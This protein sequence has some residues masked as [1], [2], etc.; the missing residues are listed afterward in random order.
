MEFTEKELGYKQYCDKEECG[1]IDKFFKDSWK[2]TSQGLDEETD[3]K[4]EE[5]KFMC[6][7]TNCNSRLSRLDALQKHSKTVHNLHPGDE[8]F[9]T[10]KTYFKIIKNLRVECVVEISEVEDPQELCDHLPAPRVLPVAGPVPPPVAAGRGLASS[11]QDHRLA[12]ASP[13]PAGRQGLVLLPCPGA[14]A[15]GHGCGAGGKGP[16]GHSWAGAPSPHT[17]DQQLQGAGDLPPSAGSPTGWCSLGAGK[18]PPLG[19]GGQQLPASPVAGGGLLPAGS[20]GGAAWR[21]Q[22]AGG[23]GQ[24]VEPLPGAAL[25]QHPKEEGRNCALP[26]YAGGRSVLKGCVTVTGN[27]SC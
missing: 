23:P 6:K 20:L 21:P 5:G 11:G 27:L 2:N 25:C 8:G 22:P 4:C 7:V 26:Q 19:A 14:G 13:Q 18:V 15:G 10:N 1:L 3:V 16:A 9:P 12:P 17:N 24:E